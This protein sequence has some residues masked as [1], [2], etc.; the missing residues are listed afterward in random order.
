MSQFE[1]TLSR[2]DNTFIKTKP[3]MLNNFYGTTDIFPYWVAD[4]DFQ[5]AQPI[6]QELD[7]LVKRGV[8]AYEFNEEGIFSA[9]SHWY[10]TRHHIELSEKNFVQVPGVLSGIALLLRQFTQAGDA[11]LIHTPAYHQFANL[12]NKADRKLVKSELIINDVNELSDVDGNG[13]QIDFE[14]FERQIQA[15]NVKAIIFCNPH[16][17]TGRVWSQAELEL[18]VAIAARHQ[19]LIISDEMHSDIIFSDSKFSSLASFDYENIITLIGSPAKTFGMHSISNGYVYTNNQ[20]LLST[21]K[22]EVSGMYLD[23]GN[24]FTSFATIAAYEKGAAWLDEMLV[25]LEETQAWIQNFIADNIPQIRVFKPEGTY[26]VWFDFSGLGLDEET[27]K[28]LVFKQAKMGLTPGIWFGA[29]SPQYM[30]MNIATSRLNI[31]KSFELLKSAVAAIGTF[32]PVKKEAKEDNTSG[33]C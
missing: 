31:V 33:C 4:M 12:I 25:Y 18:L 17:P 23:H 9:I 27:L 7:R 19:V 3:E 22:H 2:G 13:Y 1:N 10:S 26:Q 28:S 20:S 29:K 8:F 11:V 6:T 14:Q 30:R 32:E 15:E 21:I 16:N 24:A 5:V